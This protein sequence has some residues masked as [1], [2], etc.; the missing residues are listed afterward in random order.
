MRDT[1]FTGGKMS[2]KVPRQC[3][4]VLLLKVGCRESKAF[5]SGEGRAM[6]SGARGIVEHQV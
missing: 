5:G 4:L 6:R 2:V 1:T 3:P